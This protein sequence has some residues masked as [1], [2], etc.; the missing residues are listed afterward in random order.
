MDAWC[1]EGT[2]R[3]HQLRW[4]EGAPPFQADR[5]VHSAFCLGLKALAAM[6]PSPRARSS[7]TGVAASPSPACSD[8]F[9]DEGKEL[10]NPHTSRAW[11]RI[12]PASSPYLPH[13]LPLAQEGLLG[14]EVLSFCCG[15]VREVIPWTLRYRGMGPVSAETQPTCCLLAFWQECTPLHPDTQPLQR[16]RQTWAAG[17]LCPPPAS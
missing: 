2:S 10:P 15:K 16:E 11:H 9:T 7:H 3:S 13:F 17:I 4:N 14:A 1:P 8:S 6:I 5:L 12:E